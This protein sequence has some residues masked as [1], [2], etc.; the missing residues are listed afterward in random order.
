ME[1]KGKDVGNGTRREEWGGAGT[2]RGIAYQ[3]PYLW[4]AVRRFPFPVPILFPFRVGQGVV[5]LFGPE[6]AR[7]VG[8]GEE[9]RGGAGY[10]RKRKRKRNVG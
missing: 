2:G 7:L 9:V 5:F 10:E 6:D 3:P 4:A 1:R 8:R